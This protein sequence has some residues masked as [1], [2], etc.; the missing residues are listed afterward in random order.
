LALSE[1]ESSAPGPAG[2]VADG[3][4]LEVQNLTA[5]YGP[6]KVVFG[7]DLHVRRGEVVGLIGHNGAGKSTTMHAIFGT[8]RAQSGHVRFLGDEVTKHTCHKNVLAGMALARSERFVFGELSV[9]ENLLLGALYEKDSKARDE[10][11]E[12]VHTLFPILAERRSQRA[13]SFSGG[14]QRMLSI[15]MALMSN[16][17]L[18]LFD[19]PS[20]GIAPALTTQVFDT[21]RQLVDE[22]GLAVLMIEQNVP[23]L[24]RIVDR[25]YVM[26]SGRIIL[27][28]S[29]EQ[30]RAREHYW[31][32]F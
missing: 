20:L 28:E 32:L 18:I 9:H 13:G 19:E 23:Q 15:G 31:D 30:M 6:K 29:V 25:V 7:A 24:L 1:F 2:A 12:Y 27:E 8:L 14:Q 5:G 26:R 21:V 22:R 17:K 3:E 4:V 16:P 10:R 11:L